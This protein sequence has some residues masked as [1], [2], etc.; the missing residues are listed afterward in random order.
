LLKETRVAI[1]KPKAI[2]SAEFQNH[3]GFYLDRAGSEPVVITKYRRPSRVLMDY[4][5][6]S[7]LR[8][9]AM[10]R[11]TRRAVKV[12]DLEPEF[13]AALRAAD[14]SHIDPELNKLMK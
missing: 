1:H 5:A 10:H 7:R 2:S 12:E 6:Y 11:P 4:E 9:L 8:E 14:Y 13:A 3:A